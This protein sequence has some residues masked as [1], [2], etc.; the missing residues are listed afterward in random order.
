M[1]TMKQVMRMAV[2]LA[3]CVL[4]SGCPEPSG[5]LSGVGNEFEV[6]LGFPLDTGATGRSTIND[7]ANVNKVYVK[8]YNSSDEHLPAIDE[9]SN[10]SD[11]TM[12]AKNGS[13]WS[14]TVKLAAPASGTIGFEVWAVNSSG[15]HLYAGWNTLMVGQNGNSVIIPT[16]SVVTT[17][18]LG[19][20]G[21]AGGWIFYDKGNYVNGWRY[22]E[23]ASV[24]YNYSQKVWGGYGTAVGATGTAIGTGKSNTEK[25]VAKF[26]NAEPCQSKTDYAAKVCFDLVVP[27]DGVN[28]DDW[29]LPS[30]D[31]L[32]LMEQNLRLKSLGGFSFVYYWSSSEYTD[33]GAYIRDFGGSTQVFHYRDSLY[34]V[35]PI[36]AF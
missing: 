34:S 24:S 5:N 13:T 35:R 17:Y 30:K 2:L 18:T 23:A 26:G 31:E 11:V 27:K 15:V 8:V 20:T 3:L 6:S 29:F 28:Y 16:R 21:P 25:I 32:Y 12:L 4:M 19:S 14:A 36:R 7:D 33:V 22:L 10:I 1:K 9:E